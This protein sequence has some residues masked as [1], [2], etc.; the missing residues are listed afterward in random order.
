MTPTT[1]ARRP[2]TPPTNRPSRRW[3]GVVF[4]LLVG[5]A[6]VCHGCHVGDHDDELS[7]YG[8]RIKRTEDAGRD[9]AL[10]AGLRPAP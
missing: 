6:V 7:V 3:S 10:R 9:D 1:R 8:R 2:P 5:L 4:G